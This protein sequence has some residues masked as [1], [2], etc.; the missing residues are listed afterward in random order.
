M[1]WHENGV[2]RFESTHSDDRQ[3]AQRTLHSKLQQAGGRRP[4]VVDPQK[5]SYDDLRDN[6]L[7]HCVAKGNRSIKNGSDGKPTLNTIP[8]L[9]NY[10]SGWKAREVTVMDLKR[11]RTEGKE[12]GLSDARLNRYMATLRA[13]FNQARKDELITRVELPPYFPVVSEPNEARGAIFFKREWYE[14][15]RKQLSEPLRSAFVLLYHTGI[16]VHEALRLRWQ[17]IDTKK[18]IVTLPGE[19][20]KTGK[21][22]LV[23]LPSDFKRKPG[24]SDELVFPLGNFRWQWYKACIAIKAGRWEDTKPGR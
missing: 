1:T 21:P 11:F 24:K 14:P 8:R 20:T 10:F 7:A 17:H 12:E 13:M 18:M 22:R 9:D 5:V 23:P 3:F 19:I 6:F 15:L 2:K 16:R 4:T